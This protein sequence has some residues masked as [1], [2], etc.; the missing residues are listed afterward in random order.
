MNISIKTS[1]GYEVYKSGQVRYF[2]K[3]EV[4]ADNVDDLKEIGLKFY[5]DEFILSE[6][7]FELIK[8][9]KKR[10]ICEVLV[11]DL[12]YIQ[13]GKDFDA[14]QKSGFIPNHNE[15]LIYKVILYNF[16]G[17]KNAFNMTAEEKVSM[18]KRKKIVG[19]NLLKQKDYIRALKIFEHLNSLF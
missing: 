19:V 4:S 13:Y 3:E 5:L 11:Y 6:M 14:I 16:S 8:S 7:M 12:K 10:E 15:H 17:Q 18:A 9:M 2:K 1:N